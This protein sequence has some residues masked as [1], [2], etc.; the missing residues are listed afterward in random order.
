VDGTLDEVEIDEGLVGRLLEAQ[1]PDLAHLPLRA[2]GAGW[3]NVIVRIG[4]DLAARLPRRLLA[5]P[6]I[7]H[8]QRWLPGLAPRL[9]LPVPAPVRVGQPTEEFPWP[10]SIT[11]WFAGTPLLHADPPPDGEELA[12]A[13][14]G[15]A[16][17]MRSPAPVDAPENPYRG[18]PLAGRTEAVEQRCAALAGQVD[19]GRVLACWREHVALPPW[20]G[21][22]QWL[23]G[24]L[25]VLNVLVAAGHLAAV[26]DF[27]DITSGDPAT[28]LFCGWMAVG[29]EHRHELRA[30]AE[31]D[32]DTWR[33]ARGWALNMAL[34]Y[35]ESPTPANQLRPTGA[36]TL[37]AVLEDWAADR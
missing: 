4:D 5:V 10:W 21:V 15:F 3:D 30:A 23:H 32:D 9:P 19:V 34:A 29:P 14:G 36:A 12:R 22:P 16:R 17:A 13:L 33:R 24:D 20:R 27:G 26:I 6:L 35:L 37:A 8:E 7:L 11:P 31:V 2:S 25:H 18:G 1:H 28:D